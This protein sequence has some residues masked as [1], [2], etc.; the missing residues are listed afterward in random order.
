MLKIGETSRRQRKFSVHLEVWFKMFLIFCLFP[1]YGGNLKRIAN[2]LVKWLFSETQ[3]V[4]FAKNYPAE[5]SNVKCFN[6]E[7]NS[8]IGLVLVFN[9]KSD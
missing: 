6:E 1:N 7:I 4:C 9:T 5:M 3:E 2:F 8:F